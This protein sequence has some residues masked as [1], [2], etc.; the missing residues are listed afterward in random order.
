MR[1]ILTESYVAENSQTRIWICFE[2]GNV[3]GQIDKGFGKEHPGYFV[4]ENKKEGYS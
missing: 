2:L 1:R 3:I 4:Q